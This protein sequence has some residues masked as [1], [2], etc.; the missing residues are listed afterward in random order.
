MRAVARTTYGFG[1]DRGIGGR[2]LSKLAVKLRTPTPLNS[3]AGT[4]HPWVFPTPHK[5]REANSQ[6]T[7]IKTRIANHKNSSLTSILAAVDQL[8]KCHRQSAP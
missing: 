1:G 5:H 7:L 4:P 2:V 3:R 6:S 8:T